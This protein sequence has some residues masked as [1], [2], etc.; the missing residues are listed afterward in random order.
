LGQP[1]FHPKAEGIWAAAGSWE[2]DP[3]LEDLLKGIY[4]ERGRAMT[5]D[6]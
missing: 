1:L 5:E 4:R 3:C 6:G 2:D